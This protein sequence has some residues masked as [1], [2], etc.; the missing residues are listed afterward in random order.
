MAK[1]KRAHSRQGALFCYEALFSSLGKLFEPYLPH[2]IP[3]LLASFGDSTSEVREATQEATRVV[4]AH[5]TAQGVKM[6]LPYILKALDDDQW[7]TKVESIG[8]LGSMAFCAPRQLCAFLPTIVPRLTR[9]LADPHPRVQEAGK[10]ALGEIGSVIRNPE[11]QSLVPS[12]LAALTDPA[13]NTRDALQQ[14]LDTSFV[15]SV[16]A[17]SLAL[18][19]PILKRGLHDRSPS[20]KRMAA[21]IVGTI[22]EFLRDVSAILPYSG[23]LLDDLKKVLAD[24]I[25]DVRASSARAMGLLFKGVGEVHFPSLI[26]WLLQLLNTNTSSVE[27]NGGAQVFLRFFAV[28]SKLRTC[29]GPCS[30]SRCPWPYS[31]F[32]LFGCDI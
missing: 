31:A 21:Q 27:R 2:L 26:D 23:A 28:S 20:V 7:R 25:P 29:L 22:C 5:V 30:S 1:D 24:P 19:I 9:S 12:L 18:I 14:L 4:M 16:D 6:M 10:K 8:M 32:G 13:A 3:D 11:I 17:P 15:N